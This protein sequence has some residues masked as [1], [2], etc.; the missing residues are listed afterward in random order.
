[1]VY[2]SGMIGMEA[3]VWLR[4][5]HPTHTLPAPHT[6]TRR[7]HCEQGKKVVK[8]K[9]PK[10]RDPPEFMREEDRL[11]QI[12]DN[13]RRW[14]KYLHDCLVLET[15]KVGHSAGVQQLCKL[16]THTCVLVQPW[17]ACE[18]LHLVLQEAG[19]SLSHVG[20]THTLTHSLSTSER[21]C[22]PANVCCCCTQ[23]VQT[24][25]Y[26]TKLTS[27]ATVS[28]VMSEC[29]CVDIWSQAP[30]EAHSTFPLPPHTQTL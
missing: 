3:K 24:T 12:A 23:V 26:L 4:V 22:S 5:S 7:P 14:K 20:V 21:L 25:V 11:A 15:N 29:T 9:K 30:P 16:L 6:L 28:K 19:S 1:M 17:Q 13:E 10:L 2:V 18:N 27:H 8:V